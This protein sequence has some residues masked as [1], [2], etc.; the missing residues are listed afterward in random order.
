MP[1]VGAV[2]SLVNGVVLPFVIF[3]TFHSLCFERIQAQDPDVV[4]AAIAQAC[5]MAPDPASEAV[6][7]GTVADSA[8]GVVLSNA[9]VSIEWDGEGDDPAGS[10][11]T[12]TDLNGFFAFCGIPA[13]VDV[14]VTA[15]L[16]VRGDPV[17]V[18]TEPGMLHLVNLPHAFSDP[19]RPGTLTGR[20]VD[21][22]TREPV[23]G[24]TIFLW[25]EEARKATV[26]NEYGYFSLGSH[27]WGIYQ[28]RV[29]HV[30]YANIESAV[31][32]QGDMTEALEI[33]LSQ[34]PIELEEL[35][36]KSSSRLRSWDMDGLVRRMNAGFGW[37]VARDRIEKMPSVRLEHFMRD[38][39]GVKLHH[40]GAATS[41]SFRGKRCNPQIYVDGMPW[42]FEL[43]FALRQFQAD[44]LEAVEVFRSSIEIPGEFAISF[45]SGRDIDPCA[46]IAIWTRRD[47]PGTSSASAS[48]GGM[49]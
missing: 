41:M 43:D 9:R 49:L 7:A 32:I 10:S 38:I 20:V 4:G 40:S 44:Q 42:I 2:R 14:E 33:E 29:S 25:D 12:K 48:R 16:R 34:Q 26:T 47:A 17:H 27:P 6:L 30:A 11:E 28:I 24:A 36:V 15:T 18:T 35:V 45:G 31:R 19:S 3:L 39:P 1:H 46:V 23:E 13:G 8:S 21:A 37:T 22:D 5:Q